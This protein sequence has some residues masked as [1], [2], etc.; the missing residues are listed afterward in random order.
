MRS[1]LAKSC[2]FFALSLMGTCLPAI[3]DEPA[4]LPE[5]PRSLDAVGNPSAPAVDAP[6]KPI[7]VAIPRSRNTTAAKPKVNRTPT[8]VP[9]TPARTLPN[10][11][12]VVAQKPVVED[13]MVRPAGAQVAV[14]ATGN[15]SP[16]AIPIANN[17]SSAD[18]ARPNVEIRQ[19]APTQLLSGK[20][21]PIDI[22]VTNNGDHAVE[23][24]I[25]TDSIDSSVEVVTSSPRSEQNGGALVWSLGR[26]EPHESKKITFSIVSKK[27]SRAPTAVSRVSVS[28]SSVIESTIRLLTP[29]VAV[30]LAGP[31]KAMIGEDVELVLTLTNSGN[32]AANGLA[33]RCTLPQILSHSE[34]SE[35]EYEVGQLGAGETRNIPLQ[36][37]ASAAGES[38][39]AVVVTG[40]GLSPMPAEQ[41]LIVDDYQVA[42]V[43]EG[44]ESRYLN[45]TAAYKVR[46]TNNGTGMITNAVVR[47]H[48]PEGTTFAHAGEGGQWDAGT[49]NVVWK[50]P[51][52]KPN[53]TKEMTLTC[54]LAKIGDQTLPVEAAI[55]N[56]TV[57]QCAEKT[58][59]KGIAA[60]S[61]EVVDMADPLEIGS[62]TIYEI[63]VVNQGTLAV[64]NLVVKCE[65]PGE[66]EAIAADGPT[67]QAIVDNVLTFEPMKELTS[68]SEAIFRVKCRGTKEGNA[69]FKAMVKTDQLASPV[70]EEE[71]TTIFDGK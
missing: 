56:R 57:A 51:Q 33:L 9:S 22:I 6:R 10:S 71:N 52:L 4:P 64:T 43:S 49:S 39:I 21:S 8:T 2:A 38:T 65:I 70:V 36:L 44:P 28:Y 1:V 32:A 30:K 3:A 48:L 18:V 42:L 46:F 17:E 67:S 53:E 69:R 34:G 35:L 55:G 26:I 19:V 47:T 41:K 31:T 50:I 45:Q 12:A 14:P 27:G 13:S 37:K 58:E 11:S 68:Q 15:D 62:E 16:P 54:V 63:H 66:I 5:A 60:L 20:P 25:V 24:V 23:Q 29:E 61:V 59:V 40:E 7:P